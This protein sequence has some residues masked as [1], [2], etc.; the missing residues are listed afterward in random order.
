ME[1]SKQVEQ[2]VKRFR[3]AVNTIRTSENPYYAENVK[4][5]DY[6]ISKLR[7]DLEKKVEDINKQFNAE[8]DAKIADYEERA[9][10][11]FFRPTET[12]KRLVDEYIGEFKSDVMLG[13]GDRDKLEAFDRFEQKLGYLDENGLYEVKKRLPELVEHLGKDDVLLSKLKAMNVAFKQLQTAEQME[14]DALNEEKAHGAD[15]AFRR[16]R[17]TH[18]SF[19]D[20]R[21]NQHNPTRPR[22]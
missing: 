13:Y 22:F 2:E 1:Y 6:E 11:S 20:Y 8:I 16:L 10:K 14:L 12:D 5:Q 15:W 21:N 4:V 3:K 9:A 17:M 19:S 7:A 18:P